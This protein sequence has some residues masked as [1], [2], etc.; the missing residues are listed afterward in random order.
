MNERIVIGTRPWLGFLNG[1]NWLA[2]PIP[3][4]RLAALRI[5]TGL[6]LLMDVLFTYFPFRY[7]YFGPGSLAEPDV[8]A[9]HFVRRIGVGRSFG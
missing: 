4:E 5:G 9:D 3:A 8:F 7:D 2:K 1:W 6:V